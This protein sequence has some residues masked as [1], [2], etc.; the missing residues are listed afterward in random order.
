[1]QDRIENIVSEIALIS[2][3][4]Y[5]V[6]K[7]LEMQREMMDIFILLDRDERESLKSEFW[8]LSIKL[9]ESLGFKK[10]QTQRTRKLKAGTKNE[11]RMEEE[12]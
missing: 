9:A 1:M 11:P 8:S 3:K 6:D 5:D 2:R 7:L 12:D 10:K 4:N